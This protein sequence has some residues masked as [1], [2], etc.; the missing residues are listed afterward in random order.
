MNPTFTHLHLHTEYSI[1]DGIV[2][3]EP[4]IEA[5]VAAG[6]PAVAVTDQMNLFGMVK[7]YQAAIKAGIKPI[8]GVD[9]CLHNAQNPKQPFRAVFLCQN[10]LGYKNITRLISRA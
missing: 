10:Q 6:M 5:C 1:S 4:L 9:V 7:F 3:I 8:I 2:Q